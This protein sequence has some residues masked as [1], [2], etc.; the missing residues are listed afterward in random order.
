VKHCCHIISVEPCGAI[1]CHVSTTMQYKGHPVTAGEN[2][3][4]MTDLFFVPTDVRLLVMA[5]AFNLST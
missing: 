5:I 2:M 4:H 1:I 3:W